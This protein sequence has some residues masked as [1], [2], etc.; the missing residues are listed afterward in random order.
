[1]FICNK[2]KT[3]TLFDLRDLYFLRKK[4]KISV[5]IISFIK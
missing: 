1:M 2:E 3:R 4:E 5:L